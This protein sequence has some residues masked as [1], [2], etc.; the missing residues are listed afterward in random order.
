MHSPAREPL[1]EPVPGG[2]L[3]AADVSV[4]IVNYRAA[5]EVIDC[6]ASLYGQDHGRRIEVIVVDNASGPLDQR[7]FIYAE[8]LEFCHRVRRA[9]YR[10][11]HMG[12]CR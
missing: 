2:A 1:G 8:E 10:I 7:I 6:L 9:G 5:D 3:P 12:G 11:L 4:V